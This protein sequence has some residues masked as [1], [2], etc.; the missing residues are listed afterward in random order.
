MTT[1]ES[2]EL[3]EIELPLKSAFTT[4]F[5]TETVRPCILVTVRG[6]GV[7]GL[8][9]CVAGDGPWYSYETIG[10]AWHVMSE[11]LIPRLLGAE[12]NDPATV[13]DLFAPIRGHNMAKAALEMAC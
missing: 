11:F 7:Y 10:T 9:E 4:S 12:V 5:G 8:G 3:R 2:V 13:W 1:V 6:D